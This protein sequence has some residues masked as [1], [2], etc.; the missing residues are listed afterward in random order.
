MNNELSCYVKIEIK[1][2]IR[3]SPKFEKTKLDYSKITFTI[4]VEGISG[5]KKFFE[6]V[7]WRG[8]ADY[9]S[10]FKENDL[11]WVE[12]K[13]QCFSYPNKCTCGCGKKTSCGKSQRY[14]V[15]VDDAKLIYR[16]G[17]H[18]KTTTMQ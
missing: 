14:E 10:Q 1:G 3:T 13:F 2:Y 4:C 12:G 6:I 17:D 16:E 15:N 8:I 5:K 11:I 9:M 18:D 7:G